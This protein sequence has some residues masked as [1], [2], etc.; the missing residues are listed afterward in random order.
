MGYID[1]VGY[2]D[3]L[4]I[5]NARTTLKANEDKDIVDEIEKAYI[6]VL[7]ENWGQEEHLLPLGN[8]SKLHPSTPNK[9]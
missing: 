6:G 8:H 3:N 2:E 1:R 9:V 4:A 7:E 5:L